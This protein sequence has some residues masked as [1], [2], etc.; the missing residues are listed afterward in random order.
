MGPAF[1]D[2][3]AAGAIAR[4]LDGRLSPEAGAAVAIFSSFE[5]DLL[6]QL[7]QSTSGQE[8]I[9]RGFQEDVIWASQL[10]ASDCVP[11][12]QALPRSYEEVGMTVDDMPA[13]MTAGQAICFYADRL[14]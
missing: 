9:E 8:L 2:Q 7:E 13:G 5:W 6:A 14:A 3:L 4:Y 12:L 11:R 10:N 1:E